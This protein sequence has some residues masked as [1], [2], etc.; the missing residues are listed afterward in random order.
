MTSSQVSNLGRPITIAVGAANSNVIEAK[1]YWDSPGFMIYAPAS[2]SGSPTTTIEVSW[3]GTT[4]VTLNDGTADI[5][6]PAAG[7]GRFYSEMSAANY[8][9]IH[10]STNVSGADEIY[11]MSKHWTV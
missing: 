7:K 6:P 9:R 5:G 3:N 10:R 11:Q 1:E 2:I 4:F 8:F